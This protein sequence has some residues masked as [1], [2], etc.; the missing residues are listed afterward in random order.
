[1][2]HVSPVL[3]F[4]R[5]VVTG[6]SGDKPAVF[7]SLFQPGVPLLLATFLVTSSCHIFSPVDVFTISGRLGADF[8]CQLLVSG[9]KTYELSTWHEPVPPLG[10][11]VTLHVKALHGYASVC[12]VGEM[13]EVLRVVSV[14]T[15]FR[16]TPVTGS[17][18]WTPS[19][20]PIVLGKVEVVPGAAL[21]ILP[22]TVVRIIDYGELRVRGTVQMVGTTTD[23]VR[24]TGPWPGGV[25]GGPVVLD[26]AQVGTQVAFA[27]LG[28]LLVL[29]TEQVLEHLTAR[30][31]AA[32]EGRV[33]IRSSSTRS[34]WTYNASVA[35]ESA[36]LG[37]VDGIGGDFEI[38]SST[39]S[40]LQLS[41]CHA[42]VQDS[43]FTGAR[44]YVLFHGQSGGTFE[45]NSFLAAET[46]I[47]VRHAS[48]PS[49]HDNSFLS[50]S[51]NVVCETYQLSTC[52]SME[53]NWW[54][55]TDE[56]QIRTHFAAA[57][58]VCFAPWLTGP[59]GGALHP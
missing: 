33:T 23:S 16:T 21:T 10:S 39:L 29:R 38:V 14:V 11:F 7:H 54:G 49:F 57:C 34:L 12:M 45:R 46:D 56:N 18:T 26:S 58:P 22:G 25:G 20:G 55:T 35:A 3:S 37:S 28:V 30:E 40:D 32:Q 42:S 50:P 17:E 4:A 36:D 53:R 27:S 13:V 24:I 41:Y 51:T 31:I 8:G 2:S 1:M 44:S 52:I 6:F 19:Q 15:D 9:G 59:P 47:V 48:S 43:R 5:R